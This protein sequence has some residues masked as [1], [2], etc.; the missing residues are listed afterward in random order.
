M[1]LTHSEVNVLAIVDL[2][3]SDQPCR[4][5]VNPIESFKLP[6][7]SFVIWELSSSDPSSTLSPSDST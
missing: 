7:D 4:P 6:I 5:E 3:V 2:S 1:G